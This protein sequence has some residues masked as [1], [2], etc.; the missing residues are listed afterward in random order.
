MKLPEK[1]MEMD[2]QILLNSLKEKDPKAFKALFEQV[3]AQLQFYTE[4]ITKDEVE[5][6][7]ISILALTKFWQKGAGAF[8]SLPQ[9]RKFIFTTARNAAFNYLRKNKIRQAYNKKVGQTTDRIAE[10][11]EDQ[12]LYKLEVMMNLLENQIDKLPE[13]CREAFRLVYIE[14]KP[15]PEVAAILNISAS[16]VNVQCA[17]AIR[18]LREIFS[19]KE[20][21]VLILLVCPMLG[22]TLKI[23]YMNSPVLRIDKIQ[24]T[25]VTPEKVFELCD[26]R[27]LL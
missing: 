8:E 1:N 24:Q 27:V 18:K 12:A 22:S 10:A 3:Y 11:L 23:Q 25:P 17:K 6:E 26:Y 19:E 2:D 13:Q 5:A 7:D 9:V 4:Q 15:R 20:L 14:N 21:I 16:T